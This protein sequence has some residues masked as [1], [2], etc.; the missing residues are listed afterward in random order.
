MNMADQLRNL[1]E[2]YSELQFA[3]ENLRR[4]HVGDGGTAKINPETGMPLI[5]ECVDMIYAEHK[6]K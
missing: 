3:F 2:R 4:I 5:C 6:C 1:Q